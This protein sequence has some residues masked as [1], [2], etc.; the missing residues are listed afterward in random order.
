M[1]D[2]GFKELT[3]LLRA[4]DIGKT[5]PVYPALPVACVFVLFFT[6]QSSV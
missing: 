5:A 2:A 6:L 1:A 4:L 3:L